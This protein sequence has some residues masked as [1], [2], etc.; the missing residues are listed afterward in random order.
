M[1]ELYLKIEGMS[2]RH[3]VMAVKKAIDELEGVVSSEV[4]VGSAKVTYDWTKIGKEKIEDAVN[5][6]G[7]KII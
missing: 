4:T 2:C 7:Y 6:A 1:A 5:K 3:C